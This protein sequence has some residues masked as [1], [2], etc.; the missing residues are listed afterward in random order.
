MPDVHRPSRR[1]AAR[2]PFIAAAVAGALLAAC[3]QSEP[4]VSAPV[5]AAATAQAPAISA[6][7]GHYVM[8]R[9]HASLQFQVTHLGLAP[10]VLR[11][12]DFEVSLQLDP[13]DHTNSS[14]QV[15][16]DPTSVRSDHDPARYQA[17]HKSSPFKSFDEDLAQ[18]PKFLNASEHPEITFRSTRVE[19][20][21]NGHLRVAGDLS[22]LG[23]THPVSLE[24]SV[25]GSAAAHP[26]TKKGAIGFSATG[27]FQRSRFGMTHLVEPPLVSDTVTLQFNGEFQRA[28]QPAS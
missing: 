6:P 2:T 23:Q 9:N 21:P 25:T 18:S 19:P 8:D 13:E 22:L 4:T 3:S 1:P 28:D 16:I 24:A 14:V 17:T 12:V 27:S 7:A 11:F 5:A 20:M 10:Y 26:F 15:T